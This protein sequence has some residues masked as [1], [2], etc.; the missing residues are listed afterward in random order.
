MEYIIPDR[1][2]TKMEDK[3]FGKYGCFVDDCIGEDCVIHGK[4][5]LDIQDCDVALELAKV[6]KSTEDCEYWKKISEYKVKEDDV[7]YHICPNCN[8]KF[9]DNI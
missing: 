5:G 9:I 1:P 3:S 7:N 4:D 6:G 8:H 2:E